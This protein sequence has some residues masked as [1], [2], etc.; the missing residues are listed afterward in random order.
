[1]NKKI[2]I[3]ALVASFLLLYILSVYPVKSQAESLGFIFIKPDGHVE[4]SSAP[5]QWT[6]DVYTFTAHIYNP[7]VIERNNIVLDGAGHYLQRNRNFSAVDRDGGVGINVTSSNVTIMN[8][9]I[10]N[11]TA[12][13]LGAYNNNS[14]IGN[15]ITNCDKGIKVYG[16]NYTISW[17]YIANNYDGVRLFA[18]G[19]VISRNNLTD[20]SQGIN[21]AYYDHLILENNLSNVGYDIAGGGMG[22]VIIYRN[23]FF[24]TN[25]NGYNLIGYKAAWDN[26]KEGN[27]WSG[28]EGKDANRDGVGDEPYN[29]GQVY[30]YTN[31][32][33]ATVSGSRIW[34]VDNHPLM[35][36]VTVQ[37]PP[38]PS[39]S[40]TP[41]PTPPTTPPPTP[42]QTPT[43][44][45]PPTSAPSPS[46]QQTTPE[47][48]QP[49]TP[50]LSIEAVLAVIIIAATVV[51]VFALS[52]KKSH[53]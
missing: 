18:N 45:A 51:T 33:G 46:P 9:H 22:G 40:P 34:G 8:I 49:T 35:K 17:N 14:I 11:W 32:T 25:P 53:L 28:Y 12:G 44:T 30:T 1:M 47:S 6:G 42:E 5:I 43:P 36:P 15:F 16:D 3:L 2:V 48:E 37:E 10:L 41:S 24:K 50:F 13:I 39:P 38:Q 52:K 29:I 21:I 26:G 23:N 27:F 19:T 31:S 4:P 20:N 7:I